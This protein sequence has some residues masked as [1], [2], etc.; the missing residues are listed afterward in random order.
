MK[1]VLANGLL[2]LN[3]GV[4]S[5]FSIEKSTEDNFIALGCK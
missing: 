3:V 5:S 2:I 1:K 4:R